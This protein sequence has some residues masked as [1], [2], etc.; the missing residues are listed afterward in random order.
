MQVKTVQYGVGER[1][2]RSRACTAS[3]S[4]ARRR[5]PTRSWR[6]NRC[7]FGG[8]ILAHPLDDDYHQARSPVWDEGRRAAS[9]GRQLG[10]AGP[11]SAR[12]L[13]GLRARGSKQKWLE[14][15]GD[16]ALDA[17]L[18]RLRRRAAE[19]LLRPLPERRGQR[20][21]QAA[22]GAR[23]RCAIPASRFVERAENE[24]PLARTQ[25]TKFYLDPDG[26][27][28]RASRS[29][30]ATTISFDALGE[31]V[32]FLTRAAR[33][34]RPRSPGPSARSC[35]SRRPTTRRRPLPRAARVRPDLKE[36]VF[37]GAHRPA[38]A[39]RPG[40]AA[41]LASQARSE[42]VDARI[43]PITRTTSCSR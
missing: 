24:W 41:R 27:R 29:A 2:R 22:A 42:A 33:R 36:V 7:D 20:L 31:G 19:A 43:G 18:H 4:A 8:D 17:F 11:A 16:R 28:L 39:G 26:A 6:S 5:S 35:S 3:S 15:H 38:H 10:R 21:G 37:Q 30:A 14:A 40:L 23:C 9:L 34:T 13:R 12:Q 1:G 25:W 32:T